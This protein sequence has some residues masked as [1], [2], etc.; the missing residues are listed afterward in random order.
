MGKTKSAATDHIEEKPVTKEV[1]EKIVTTESTEKKH[2]DTE[3]S[4][5]DS[6]KSETLVVAVSSVVASLAQDESRRASLEDQLKRALADYR[7][8]ERRVDDERKLLSQLSSI[9]LIEKLLPILDNLESAQKHLNDQGLEMVIKQFKDV[10]AQEGVEEI[11][12]EGV[13]F[14]PKLHEAIEVIE[15]QNDGKIVKVVAKGYKIN[16]KVIRPVKVAVERT[17]VDQAAEQ[18]AQSGK[19]FGD[20]A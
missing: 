14:D 8:L 12:A 18:K 3:K 19:E 2:E 15:G 7:N 10:L 11:P 1:T 16:D 13:Q 20:Y 17:K 5:Q 9:I 6:S 4:V